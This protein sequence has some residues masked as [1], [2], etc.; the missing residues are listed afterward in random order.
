MAVP[1]HR[2]PGVA[3][4]RSGV[5]YATVRLLTSCWPTAVVG[6]SPRGLGRLHRELFVVNVSGRPAGVLER[7]DCA[8]IA[9]GGCRVCTGREAPAGRVRCAQHGCASA[10]GGVRGRP[11]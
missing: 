4:P 10:P 2:W 7:H 8:P 6:G 9:V 5:G 11:V 3:A 1:A